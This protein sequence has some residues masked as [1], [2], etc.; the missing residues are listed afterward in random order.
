M[1]HPSAVPELIRMVE[2][3]VLKLGK[4]GGTEVL[5]CYPLDKWHEAWDCSVDNAGVGKTVVVKP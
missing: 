1:Y 5:G 4:E 3:G 2:N